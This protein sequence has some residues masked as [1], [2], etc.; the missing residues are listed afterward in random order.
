MTP[1]RRHDYVRPRPWIPHP[2]RTIEEGLCAAWA[3]G[4]GAELCADPATHYHVLHR[5]PFCAAH[6]ALCGTETRLIK[7]SRRRERGSISPRRRFSI[8]QRDGFR[9]QLCGRTAEHDLVAL[10]VDHMQPVS[11]GGLDDDENLWTLCRD[12]NQGKTDA[13]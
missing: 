12:C 13:L 7:E 3:H 9:C 4:E 1:R 6:A 8:L 5:I 2:S 10:E 11:K